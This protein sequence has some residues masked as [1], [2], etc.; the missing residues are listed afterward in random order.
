MDAVYRLGETTAREL[1]T[2]LPDSLANATVRTM[3]RI[4]EEKGHLHH[5]E[6]GRTF[7][8]RPARA[9]RHEA[10]SALRRL[11]GVFYDDSVTQAFSGMLDLP[12]TKLSDEELDA[13]Q[14]MIDSA[15]DTGGGKNKGRT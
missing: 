6:D 12:D 2:E 11:L 5:R 9:K 7:V 15:R 3:L 4:L 14:Q 10:T 1:E 8:Y 13:L